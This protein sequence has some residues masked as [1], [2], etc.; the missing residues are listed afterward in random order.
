MER[1]SFPSLSRRWGIIIKSGHYPRVEAKIDAASGVVER[2]ESDLFISA[3]TI[4]AANMEVESDNWDTTK[5][6]FDRVVKLITY[7][8]IK[9][10]TTL[11]ELALWKTGINQADISS[12]DDRGAHR[13]DVPGPVKDTVLQYLNYYI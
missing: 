9:E 1:F 6:C 2:R 10:A 7:Y 13:E 5:Q 3:V 11:F 12:P 8:E 4:S